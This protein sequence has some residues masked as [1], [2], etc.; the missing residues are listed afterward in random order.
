MPLYDY[1]CVLCETVF[2]ELHPVDV[3]EITCHQCGCEARRQVSAPRV[4]LFPEGWAD[5]MDTKPVYIKNKKQ[6]RAECKKRGLESK[7]LD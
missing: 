4:H 7:I 6:L 1:K 3:N 5:N 2:E